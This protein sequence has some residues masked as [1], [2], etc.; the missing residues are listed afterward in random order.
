M[1]ELL[2]LI[3]YELRSA[4]RFRWLVVVA[5]WGVGVLGLAVAVVLPN[6][7]EASARIYVDGT[8]VLRPLLA[9]QIVAPNIGTQLAFVRQS[10]LGRAHLEHVAAENGLD[11]SARTPDAREVLLERLQTEI[12]IDAVPANRD[13]QGS[14]SSIFTI[15]YR[16][17]S[18]EVAVGVVRS[19]VSSLIEDTLGANR[20]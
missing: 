1:Q 8:S 3:V 11:A 10:L 15:S 18:T 16:H 9:D 14:L 7:Y 20:E 4:W 5:A 17:T 13:D 12:I 2:Q 19:M 6:V